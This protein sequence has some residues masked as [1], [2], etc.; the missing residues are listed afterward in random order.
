LTSYTNYFVKRLLFGLVSIMLTT[1]LVSSIIF[2]IPVDPT[3]MTFGQRLDEATL[4][5]KTKEYGLDQSLT[6]QMLYYFRD[7]SPIR[8]NRQEGQSFLKWPNL[9]ESYQSGRSVNEILKETWPLTLILAITSITLATIMGL[10]LGWLAALYHGQWIDKALL[11]LGVIGYS[12]PSYVSALFFSLTFGYF[13]HH[14]THLE[15]QGSLIELNNAGEEVWNWKNLILPTLALGIR[16]IAVIQQITRSSL[17]GVMQENYMISAKAKGLSAARIWWH[18]GLKNAANPI[19]STT[20]SWFAALLA[21]AFFVETIFNYHGIGS[22]TVDALLYFDIPLLLGCIISV[23]ML[24]IVINIL[25][26]LLYLY[27]D[28]SMNLE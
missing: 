9:R 24:L 15:L 16:P 25:T 3:R 17:L 1:L 8:W 26:D 22:T 6:T 2:L 12:V 4:E 5:A 7:I 20:T 14:W 21:G 11:S 19:V 23:G 13:L 28:P 10:F 27:F 18:H